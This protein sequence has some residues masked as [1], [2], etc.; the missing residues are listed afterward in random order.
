MGCQTCIETKIH[1]TIVYLP[2]FS[3]NINQMRVNIPYHEFYGSWK[4]EKLFITSTETSDEMTMIG[5]W[6]AFLWHIFAV[7][8]CLKMRDPCKTIHGILWF[9]ICVYPDWINKW[10]I[11]GLGWWFGFLG[12]PYERDCYLGVSLDSRIPN[13]QPKPTLNT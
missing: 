5:C 9:V 1:G 4:N 2:T 3:I 7:W 6:F 11:G 10:L 12:S 13:H 8:F